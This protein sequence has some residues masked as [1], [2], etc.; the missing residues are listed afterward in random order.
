MIVACACHKSVVSLCVRLLVP[1]TDY[2][3]ATLICFPLVCGVKMPI[4]FQ[5]LFHSRCLPV[6]WNTTSAS[7]GATDRS[8]F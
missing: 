8:H 5:V 2:L 4:A 3:H 6:G 1:F 7:R